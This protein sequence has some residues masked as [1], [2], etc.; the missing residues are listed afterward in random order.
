MNLDKLK[1]IKNNLEVVE[2]YVNKVDENYNMLG[3]VGDNIPAIMP[4]EESSSITDED[5]LVNIKNV[6]NKEGKKI[7]CCIIDVITNIDKSITV[8][9]S[10]RALEM[11]VRR[12]MFTNLKEG[13][14]LKGIVKNVTNFSAFI[15][16]GGGVIGMIKE[17]DLN[18]DSHIDISDVLWYGKRIEVIVKKFD[19][20]TGKIDLLYNNANKDVEKIISKLEEG[21]IHEAIVT[22]V[23]KVGVF[24]KLKNNLSA[25]SPHISGIEIGKNVM[26]SI[27]KINLE[28]KKIKVI[29]IG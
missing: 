27:K 4:R 8:I 6:S 23:S 2:M 7:K 26:V 11:K 1:K 25:V 10:K 28:T 5:G 13:V 29:I 19:R 18:L 14:K 21:S 12:W 3:I 17:S 20:D 22:G 24:L 15:D 9:T 16:V